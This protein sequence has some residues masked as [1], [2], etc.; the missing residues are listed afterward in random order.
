MSGE[1]LVSVIV[2]VYNVSKYIGRCIESILAQTYTVLEVL[3]IDDGST[4]GSGALCDRYAKCDN[5]I[6]VVH[7]QNAGAGKAREKGVQLS[8]GRYIAFVDADDWIE[9]LFLETLLRDITESGADIACCDLREM[10]DGR[11]TN[12][13]HTCTD[14]RIVRFK[15]DFFDDLLKGGA[16]YGYVVWGKL[17]RS[18]LVRTLPFDE[19]RFG[20]DTLYMLKVLSR[21]P[22]V[23]LNPYQ[24]YVYVRREGSV[25]IQAGDVCPDMA[26]NYV[27][28]GSAIKD[29][30]EELDRPQRK[31]A[32]NYYAKKVYIALSFV[33]RAN[34]CAAEGEVRLFLEKHARS[35]LCLPDLK[36]KLRVML[37]WYLMFPR[38][39]D[40]FVGCALKW[41]H[42]GDRINHA[43]G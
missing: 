29:F 39:Y 12:R 26:L 36:K 22:I 32:A 20:E 35:A 3:L 37:R 30:A 28:I 34:G 16:K 21:Q 18:E 8:R 27:Y 5:R 15:K 43:R 6:R 38:G 4:D 17:F 9:R 25:T 7:Q 41:K 31:V 33:L 14:K 13:F 1:G 23:S 40:V 42:I 19:I 10:A 2:P 11:E 24:G